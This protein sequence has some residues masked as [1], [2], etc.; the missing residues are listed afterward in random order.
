MSLDTVHIKTKTKTECLK[1]P[2]YAI[3]ASAI[4]RGF[5]DIKYLSFSL[6][7]Q[8][9]TEQDRLLVHLADISILV[10]FFFSKPIL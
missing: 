6:V 4:C 7:N 2:T 10:Q 3:S 9:R 1:D 8:I 5:K